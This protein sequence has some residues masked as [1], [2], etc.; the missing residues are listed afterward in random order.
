L[1]KLRENPDLIQ[2]QNPKLTPHRFEVLM[3]EPLANRFSGPRTFIEDVER[4]VPEFYSLVG[5]HLKAWQPK[6]PK[7]VA[8]TKAVS[9]TREDGVLLKLSNPIE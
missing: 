2:T 7:P 1:L 4:L 3:V 9:D 5:Q 6:A 8:A